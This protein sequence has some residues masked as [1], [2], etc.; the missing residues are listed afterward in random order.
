MDRELKWRSA[1]DGSVGER[2]HDRQGLSGEWAG[3]AR[4]RGVDGASPSRAVALT[5]AAADAGRVSPLPVRRW[6]LAVTQVCG[7]ARSRSVR[8]TRPTDTL[9]CALPTANPLAP[10]QVRWRSLGSGVPLPTEVVTMPS[11]ATGIR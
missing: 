1:E 7:T 8:V 9:D 2:D 5:G 11:L 10:N 3:Y 4:T 6:M